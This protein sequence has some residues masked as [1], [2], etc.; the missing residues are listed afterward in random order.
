MNFLLVNLTEEVRNRATPQ[1]YATIYQETNNTC[2]YGVCHYCSPADPVCGVGDILEG[3]LILWLPSYLKLMKHRHPWQ[4]TYKRNKLALWETDSSY[5][6]KV[7][8]ADKFFL[9]L[10]VNLLQFVEKKNVFYI[11]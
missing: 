1:L 6:D 9:C 2:L 4:R 8:H 3:S 7:F 11:F 5:C 10:F